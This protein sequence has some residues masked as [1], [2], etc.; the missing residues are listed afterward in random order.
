MTKEKRI[1]IVGMNLGHLT[2]S[3]WAWATEH[4]SGDQLEQRKLEIIADL[5]ALIGLIEAS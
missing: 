4:E 1:G 5:K 3:L 2:K